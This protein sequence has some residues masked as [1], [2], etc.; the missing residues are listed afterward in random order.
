MATA[1]ERSLHAR[2]AVEES[3]ARTS[4][5]TARTAAAR[6]TFRR[7]FEDEVDPEHE[8]SPEARARR[9]EHAR[10]AFYARL[11]LKS[12]QAKRR[13]REANPGRRESNNLGAES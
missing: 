5:P 3:W 8:L 13:K 2:L 11:A 9:G 12:A 1:A 10:R 7:K 4:D 6:E